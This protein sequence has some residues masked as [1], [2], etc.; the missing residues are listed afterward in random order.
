MVVTDAS[1]GQVTHVWGYDGT[2]TY[3]GNREGTSEP[4]TI[5]RTPQ[6]GQAPDLVN[7][8]LGFDVL[9]AKRIFEKAQKDP[10]AQLIGQETWDDGRIVHVLR[11]QQLGKVFS[12]PDTS[13]SATPETTSTLYFDRDTYQLIGHQEMV[14]RDGETITVSS[15]RQALNEILPVTANIAWN[16]SDLQGVTIVEDSEAEHG[17]QLPILISEQ[18]LATRVPNAYLLRTLPA[19]FKVEITAPPKFK[20]GEEGIYLVDYRNANDEFFHLQGGTGASEKFSAS[21]D[22]VY[23]TSSGLKLY[24]DPPSRDEIVFSSATAQA[25]DGTTFFITAKLPRERV[26]QLAEDLVRVK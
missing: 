15:Y 19:G 3:S 11:L 5:Y 6:P 23:T 12:R 1:T 4:L 21:A 24:F 25:P 18:E 7:A 17:D 8:K 2:H 16:M 9:D 13:P 20:K 26:K 22:E 10:T 14:A